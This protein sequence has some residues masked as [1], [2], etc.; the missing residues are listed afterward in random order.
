MKIIAALYVLFFLTIV[1]GDFPEGN[2]NDLVENFR[3]E[4]SE[5]DIPLLKKLEATED[6]LLENDF[7]PHEEEDGSTRT[8]RC[9]SKKV[10]CGKD[11]DCC[12]PTRC[13]HSYF[14]GHGTCTASLLERLFKSC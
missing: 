12:C 14:K 11:A 4:L 3:G 2:E 1:L 6:A 5:A 7:L 13:I 8:K 10:W 9:T